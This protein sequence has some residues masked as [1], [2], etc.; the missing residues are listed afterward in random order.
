MGGPKK[1]FTRS[2]IGLAVALLLAIPVLASGALWLI[3]VVTAPADAV[4]L[5]AQ[6]PEALR[7]VEQWPLW[8]KIAAPLAGWAT[9]AWFLFGA[10]GLKKLWWFLSSTDRRAAQ[11]KMFADD[12]ALMDLREKLGARWILVTCDWTPIEPLQASTS[13]F[14][15]EMFSWKRDVVSQ[16]LNS[17]L[18]HES[19]KIAFK[20][21]EA[22][23]AQRPEEIAAG[24]F[25]FYNEGN[26]IR[27]NESVAMVA[28]ANLFLARLKAELE[29]SAG[30]IHYKNLPAHSIH[31]W[32]ARYAA[33]T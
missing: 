13:Q 32:V 20:A 25:P 29:L 14:L 28:E 15:S 7:I 23:A 31:A 16:R 22:R 27:Y 5:L 21:I 33:A 4:G 2:V 1:N 17:A 8:L 26:R 6:L 19:S 11:L 3:G 18:G 24:A 9:Y 10:D 12:R 30:M